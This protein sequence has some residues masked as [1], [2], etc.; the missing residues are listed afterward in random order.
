MYRLFRICCILILV[1]LPEIFHAQSDITGIWVGVITRDD[2]FNRD[3]FEFKLYLNQKRSNVY[4]RSYVQ[5]E[6]LSATMEL[7]GTMDDSDFFTFRE[8][9]ILNFEVYNNLDWC[10]KRGNLLLVEIDGEMY[11]KGKWTGR[12][13]EKNYNCTPGEMLVKL[14]EH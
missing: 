3:T 6:G 7:K 9:S 4:G 2:G 12:T 13:A 14:I 11:L 10:L 5:V 8:T 1:F